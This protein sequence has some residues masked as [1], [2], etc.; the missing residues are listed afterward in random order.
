MREGE[1]HPGILYTQDK[2]LAIAEALAD[3][4]VS[5]IE[6]PLV[7]PQRGGRIP[8]INDAI[9]LVQNIGATAILQFRAYRPDLE[10]ATKFNARGAGVF[11]AISEEQ[12]AKI[13]NMTDNECLERLSES[14]LFL[15]DHGFKYR[16]AVLEDAGRYFTQLTS[17]KNTLE[18]FKLYVK[19]VEAAGATV[20]SVPDTS[21]LLTHEQAKELI[22][23]ARTAV[24]S[25][26]E[27]AGHFHNDYGNSL[28]NALAV[29]TGEENARV[30]EM[31]TSIGGIGARNGITD[32]YELV[33]NLEDNFGIKTGIRRDG[34]KHLYDFY[35][36]VMRDHYTS[37]DCLA[38]QVAVEQAG[39]HQAQQIRDPGGY[40]PPLKLKN[41]IREIKFAASNIMSRHVMDE[42]MSEYDIGE[43]A[44]RDI[45][46]TI[47]ERS[48]FISRT[49]S[50]P[51]VQDI[52]ES[53]TG[54]RV[55][56]EDVAKI[57]YGGKEHVYIHLNVRPQYPAREIIDELYNW[58]EVVRTDEVYGDIDIV[59][60]AAIRDR[61]GKYTVDKIRERFQDAI[62][63]TNTL[64]LE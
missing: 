33:A 6:F 32:F 55:P 4:G 31:H 18:R 7:Y 12:K 38:P 40:I 50:P 26:V 45:T 62:L 34:L 41:D 61:D 27:I 36:D 3:I 10:L 63:K 51:E 11:L 54:V 44:I 46:N 15:K 64:T 42:V 5:R 56:S 20:I 16:R 23:S 24:T 57:V 2:R 35:K 19:S 1:L 52:I 37:R 47:A 39:T 21:G 43:D 28:G 25:D 48:V 8:D 53:V 49:V 9:D 29:T 22:R 60:L 17:P 58:A 14:L 30:D 59:V 13:G